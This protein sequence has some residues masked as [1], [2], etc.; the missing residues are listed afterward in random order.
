MNIVCD[1]F[2]IFIIKINPVVLAHAH[3]LASHAPDSLRESLRE[4]GA[5]ETTH[6]YGLRFS[7]N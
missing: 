3:S 2:N 7:C 6:S 1:L 5:R 4:S